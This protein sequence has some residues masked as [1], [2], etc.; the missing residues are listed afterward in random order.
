M[1]R[2][3]AKLLLCLT[4][5]TGP[6]IAHARDVRP[7]PAAQVAA[8][9]EDARRVVPLEQ[10]SNFRD[11]GGYRAADGKTVRWGRIYRSGGTPMITDADATRIRGL[12]ISRMM[13]L[14]SSEERV[15][16]P[17][18][19]TGVTYTAISYSMAGL[20]GPGAASGTPPSAEKMYRAFPTMLAPQLRVLFHALA[21]N[22]QPIV[23]NCS[24]G[25]DRTGF[26]TAVILT[27][28]GVSRDEVI[29]DY[30]KSTALR[31]PQ[32]EMPRI[33]PAR[34]AGDPVALMFAKWQ[35]QP[36]D[37]ASPLYDEGGAYLRYALDEVEKRWGSMDNYLQK[38]VS[39]P[40]AEL[41]TIRA[42]YLN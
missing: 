34:H 18:R 7:A 38:E 32:Y 37:K 11:I 9:A 23:Y 20:M 25:Q 5:L 22:D 33:D 29:K 17:S 2:K 1:T 42:N 19:I 26:T 28:L 39:V 15:L 21:D 35:Q 41:A 6:Q 8:P 40:P 13:D 12:G 3:I 31:R 14:R 30:L 4:A 24:A 10:G 27:T 16:A 36:H